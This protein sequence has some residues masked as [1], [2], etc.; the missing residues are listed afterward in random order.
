MIFRQVHEPAGPGL[1]DFTD[2]NELGI[3]VAGIARMPGAA[4]KI[5]AI[6]ESAGS[7]DIGG[8]S[9]HKLLERGDI[10][11]QSGDGERHARLSICFAS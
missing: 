4:F 1:S 6:S 9:Q 3:T 10:V 2:M 5:G 7:F 11:G 8:L